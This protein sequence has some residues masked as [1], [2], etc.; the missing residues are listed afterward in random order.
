MCV[1]VLLL[2]HDMW[3]FAHTAQEA[4]DMGFMAIHVDSIGWG[5]ALALIL[6]FIFRSVAKKANAGVPTGNGQLC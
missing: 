2:P 6:G 1:T 4:T 3:T 5:I